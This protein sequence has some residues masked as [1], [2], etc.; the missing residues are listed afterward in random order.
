MT[1]EHASGHDIEQDPRAGFL[2]DQEPVTGEHDSEI[3]DELEGV[4]QS[5]TVLAEADLSVLDE[6][7]RPGPPRE[8]RF[9]AFERRVLDSGLTVVTCHTP[10]RALLAANLILPG[11]VALEPA[12]RAGATVLL[13]RALTEGTH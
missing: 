5:A 2:T 3:A 11:G 6:R 12:E 13:A 1:D 7:P 4:P 10:G 8:Y 9:P